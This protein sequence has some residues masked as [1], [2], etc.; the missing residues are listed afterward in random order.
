[1]ELSKSHILAL[2]N[3][4]NNEIIEKNF[5]NENGQLCKGSFYSDRAILAHSKIIL[6]ETLGRG[7]FSKVKEAYDLKNARQIA[8]KIIDC[9][10][11]PKDFQVF[12]FQLIH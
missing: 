1:M 12:F 8:V 2:L 7:S 11:A 3:T 4:Y 10:K 6:R 5:K 9:S